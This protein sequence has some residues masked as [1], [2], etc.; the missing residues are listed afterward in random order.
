MIKNDFWENFHWLWIR[1]RQ[2]Y[3]LTADGG[4]SNP[5]RGVTCL[6]TI[7]Y[8]CLC[9]KD[10]KGVLLGREVVACSVLLKSTMV[11]LWSGIN[12][13]I[14][15]M[16]LLTCQRVR[17]ALIYTSY[18]PNFLDCL[19][20]Y[21]IKSWQLLFLQRCSSIC[22]EKLIPHVPMCNVP[23]RELIR[24]SLSILKIKF[25]GKNN[26][27]PTHPNSVLGSV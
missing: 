27:L 26:L 11:R 19:K 2:R 4:I 21:P 14:I 23:G 13:R 12:K 9:R 3:C 8:H 17:L 7:V 22:S 25:E 15:A 16:V 6:H 18:P 5:S 20:N 24:M 1:C 10:L